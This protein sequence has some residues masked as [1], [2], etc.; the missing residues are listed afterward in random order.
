MG[1]YAK[2][3]IKKLEERSMNGESLNL[4]NKN[5]RDKEINLGINMNSK[6]S[7]GS[8][9]LFLSIFLFNSFYGTLIMASG[10]VQN[11]HMETNFFD[12]TYLELSSG[13]DSYIGVDNL[14]F[15]ILMPAAA[16]I[17]FTKLYNEAGKEENFENPITLTSLQLFERYDKNKD[18]S[19]FT[20]ERIELKN[21][22]WV[23]YNL[24]LEKNGNPNDRNILEAA[25]IFAYYDMENQKS[26]EKKAG[27]YGI[28]AKIL[29]VL[30]ILEKRLDG[31]L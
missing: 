19:L 31:K 28:I 26:E 15:S 4:D 27:Y 21:K 10:R 12:I 6:A 29:N 8:L 13:E 24:V 20:A 3:S 25:S 7:L 11:V 9:F 17:K 18:S 22:P 2:I 16:Q 30:D 23:K 1:K 5:F 14:K